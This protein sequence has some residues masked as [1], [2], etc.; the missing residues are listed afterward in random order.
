VPLAALAGGM[1]VLPVPVELEPLL[2]EDV[3]DDEPVEPVDGLV[4]ED[5]EEPGVVV[6]LSAALLQ[7]D[8]ASA[9]VRASAAAEPVFSVN[10]YISMFPLI[11]GPAKCQSVANLAG[12][13][14]RTA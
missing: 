14:L 2:P 10:A 5:E 3:P 8:N 13:S 6:E 4:E 1:D 12:R 7:P 11:N 9:A